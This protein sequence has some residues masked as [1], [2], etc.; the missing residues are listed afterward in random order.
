MCPHTLVIYVNHLYKVKEAEID[1]TSCNVCPHL[2][3]S[4]R[5]KSDELRDRDLQYLLTVQEGTSF[6][7]FTSVWNTMDMLEVPHPSN[8]KYS[9]DTCRIIFFL[10]NFFCPPTSLEWKLIL[11]C[12]HLHASIC[13]TL[14]QEHSCSVPS[15]RRLGGNRKATLQPLNELQHI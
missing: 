6:Q 14:Q 2:E 9:L 15:G 1:D 7:M 13:T 4:Q 8:Q 5:S 10:Q 3:N 12:R 11:A